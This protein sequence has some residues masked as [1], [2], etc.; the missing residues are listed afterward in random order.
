MR[1]EGL[2]PDD[3]VVIPAHNE[4]ASIGLVVGYLID[5]GLRTE[6]LLVVDSGCTDGTVARARDAA[7]S[8]G[9]SLRII[10]PE[11][12]LSPFLGVLADKYGFHLTHFGGKG[13]A[14][15]SALLMLRGEGRMS[16]S[17]VFFLD[18]DITNPEAVDPIGCLLRG[19]EQVPRPHIV[20][21]ASEGRDNE[22]MIAF[23]NTL[24][25]PYSRLSNL[26]WPLCGQQSLC[27]H[28]L[29]RVPFPVGYC[30]EMALLASLA[31]LYGSWDNEWFAQVPIPSALREEACPDSVLHYVVRMYSII[32]LFLQNAVRSGGLS[33]MS[34][35][36]IR[37]WNGGA[38]RNVSD[39]GVPSVPPQGSVREKLVVDALLPPVVSLTS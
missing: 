9:G 29:A 4:E 12:V 6:Q 2:L 26:A 7:K 24:P 39:V 8:H 38:W 35:G 17:R 3:H 5:H 34:Q 22:G 28:D 32:M 16:D 13:L 21:L 19:W 33:E 25:A 36:D 37:A 10:K 30:V 15:Y 14:M 20:K 11:V 1:W 27:L 31:E 18:G 23:L